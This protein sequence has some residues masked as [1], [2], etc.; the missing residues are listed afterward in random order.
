MEPI[1]EINYKNHVIK[2]VPD[3][4]TE[5]P[6]EWDNL[7]TICYRHRNYILGDQSIP[8]DIDNEKS[9]ITW[10]EAMSGDKIVVKLPLSIYDHSGITMYVGSG[11]GWDT[12]MIGWIVAT[13][14]NILNEYGVKRLSK[15]ILGQVEENLRGEIK[16]Y[17]TYLR[18]EVVGYQVEGPSCDDSCCGYYSDD[19][20][21][22]AAKG[23]ID[24]SIQQ[25]QLKHQR[26]LKKYIQ[27]SVPIAY[28]FLQ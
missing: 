19:D 21:I 13:R 23:S 4:D 20:A 11:S 14:K 26:Q 2:I 17:D 15:K 6:R 16:N 3:S 28:R 24:C 9:F 10:Y 25:T 27:S 7:G 8:S 18:G 1:Q 12:S 22:Q 5:S